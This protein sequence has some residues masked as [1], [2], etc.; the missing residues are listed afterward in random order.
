MP[1]AKGREPP[2]CNYITERKIQTENQRTKTQKEEKKKNSHHVGMLDSLVCL[3]LTC[4]WTL[5]QNWTFCERSSTNLTPRKK[6]TLCNIR[7][8]QNAI[9]CKQNLFLRGDPEAVHVFQKVPRLAPSSALEG[10][11]LSRTPPFKLLLSFDS[12]SSHSLPLSRHVWN[13]PL[14]SNT[15]QACIYKN[16]SSWW[17]KTWNIWSL[18]GCINV[19]VLFD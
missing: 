16:Q 2:G 5:G 4:V 19:L 15:E 11:R 3:C 7:Q 1:R 12:L 8:Q 14:P 9:V 17:G 18:W 13:V 10:Q 6:A